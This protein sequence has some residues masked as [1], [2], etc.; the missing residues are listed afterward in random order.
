MDVLLVSNIQP[1]LKKINKT[2]VVTA[3]GFCLPVQSEFK[4]VTCSVM[5]CDL[6]LSLVLSFIQG[7]WKQWCEWLLR[8]L[9][10]LV[11]A[12]LLGWSYE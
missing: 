5:S 10:L 3:P 9:I 4:K 11:K 2:N 12:W 1:I 8:S 6:P 7:P